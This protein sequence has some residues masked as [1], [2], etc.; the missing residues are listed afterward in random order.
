MRKY[1]IVSVVIAL[2]IGVTFAYA[3]NYVPNQV[4]VKFKDG[5]SE[6][7]AT[8]IHTAV[9]TRLQD[10]IIFGKIHLVVIVN[11]ASVEDTVKAYEKFAEVEFA[12]PNDTSFKL[13]K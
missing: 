8:E 13:K 2:M 7:R 1:V 5:I 4:L 11:G 12:E 6:K 3:Q 9:G 10:K